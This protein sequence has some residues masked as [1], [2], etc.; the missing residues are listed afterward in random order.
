MPDKEQHWLRKLFEKGI[1]GFYSVALDDTGWKVYA[2]QQ[3]NWQIEA[4]TDGI[5]AILP[6]MKTDIVLE[7]AATESR[8]ILDTKFNAITTRGW[9]R[10][11]TLRSGYIYQMYAY[12]R[13]QEHTDDVMSLNSTGM[14]LHPSINVEVDESIT[15]Q[16]HEI[17]F[18]TVNLGSNAAMIREQ[19]LGLITN[20]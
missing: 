3:C 14:L 5:D 2:G 18:C 17:R 7:N 16:G 20:G 10:D 13:T 4:R 9:H 15:T 19:L 1:A 11:Q 8:L 12:L 6:S